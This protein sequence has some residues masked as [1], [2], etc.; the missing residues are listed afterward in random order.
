MILG[1]ENGEETFEVLLSETQFTCG[2]NRIRTRDPTVKS[3]GL[4]A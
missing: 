2:M 4:A 1:G 3:R